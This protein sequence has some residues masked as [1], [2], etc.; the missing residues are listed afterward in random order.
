MSIEI[1]GI[2]KLMRKLGKAAANKVLEK[3]MNRALLRIQRDMQEYP[4]QPASSR[5]RRTGTLGR[6]W[7]KRI[8]KNASGLLGRVGNTTRYGPWVQSQRF[9][10]RMHQETG[11]RTDEQVIQEHRREII[12]DFVREINKALAEG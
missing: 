2:N 8:F 1:Q 5:Y 6:R 3:P 11:W 10:T 9:Q 7:T 12:I 4:P